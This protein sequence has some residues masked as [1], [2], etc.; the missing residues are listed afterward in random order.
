MAGE[1]WDIPSAR[2]P[3]VIALRAWTA[4]REL[5]LDPVAAQDQTTGS[6]GDGRVDHL[7][8][9]AL[10]GLVACC[11]SSTADGRDHDSAVSRDRSRGIR[12]SRSDVH[13]QLSEKPHAPQYPECGRPPEDCIAGN[14]V[15]RRQVHGHE[16]SSDPRISPFITSEPSSIRRTLHRPTNA[17]DGSRSGSHAAGSTLMVPRSRRSPSRSSCWYAS[18]PDNRS[19][20]VDSSAPRAFAG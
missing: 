11:G 15:R 19:L 5:L 1:L 20:T 10:I 4:H 8:A 17:P 7:R 16:L 14:L 6:L 9:P 12:T 13:R 3:C 2:A 18:R